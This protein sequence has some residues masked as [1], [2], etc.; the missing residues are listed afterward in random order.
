MNDN[1]LKIIIF[2][3]YLISLGLPSSLIDVFNYVCQLHQL[4][5]ILGNVCS[6]CEKTMW[7][8]SM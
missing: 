2:E 4:L 3:K 1:V 8:N 5:I 6:A 7:S